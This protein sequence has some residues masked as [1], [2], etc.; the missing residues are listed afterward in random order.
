MTFVLAIGD[1][2]PPQQ[3]TSAKLPPPTHR[4]THQPKAKHKLRSYAISIMFAYL[5]KKIARPLPAVDGDKKKKFKTGDRAL[6]RSLNA[7]TPSSWKWNRLQNEKKNTKNSASLPVSTSTTLFAYLA[8]KI[9]RPLPAVDGDK[10][11]KFKTGDRALSRSLNAST[12]SSKKRLQNEKKNTKNSAS[13]PVSTSTTLASAEYGTNIM[14]ANDEWWSSERDGVAPGTKRRR[15]PNPKFATSVDT[16]VADA[17]ANTI[18]ATTPS[19]PK[20]NPILPETATAR[21]RP[22]NTVEH[23]TPKS[24]PKRNRYITPTAVA[25][26]EDTT[27][28]D[29]NCNEDTKDTNTIIPQISYY[30]Y[31]STEFVGWRRLDL[32]EKLTATVG[33]FYIMIIPAYK[34]EGV[35]TTLPRIR[36]NIKRLVKASSPEIFQDVNMSDIQSTFQNLLLSKGSIIRRNKVEYWEFTVEVCKYPKRYD[37]SNPNFP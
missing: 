5:A 17:A 30:N 27:E 13:L 33:D 19:P 4:L 24:A 29:C 25:E 11:K 2:H 22:I 6:S 32:M 35:G 23:Q 3:L 12:P 36:E 18:A 37:L 28:E 26:G 7:S 8:K 1:Y 14:S 21:K 15:K 16:A 34:K 31:Q 10:K 20:N 9:A